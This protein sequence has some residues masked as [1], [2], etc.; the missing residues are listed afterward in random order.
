VDEN[1]NTVDASKGGYEAH[2]ESYNW[3]FSDIGHLLPV[4][5]KN[6]SNYKPMDGISLGKR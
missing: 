2:P 4:P 5:S 6:L 1:M 3:K